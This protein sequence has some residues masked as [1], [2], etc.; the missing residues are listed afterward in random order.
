MYEQEVELSVGQII[1][2]G[3][4]LVT[5]LDIDN[6]EVHIQIDTIADGEEELIGMPAEVRSLP[7]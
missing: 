4:V 3:D 7:R 5:I 6:G 2:V 1:R